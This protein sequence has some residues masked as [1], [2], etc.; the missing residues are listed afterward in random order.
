MSENQRELEQFMSTWD[1][2]AQKTLRL[3]ENLPPTQYEFRP[4]TAG[5]SLGELAWHLA[6]LEAYMTFGIEVGKFDTSPKPPGIER[7]REVAALAPGYQRVH[8]QAVARVRRLEP[9]DVARRIPF[10]GGQDVEVREILRGAVLHHHI[11]HRGQLALVCRL[12][13]GQVPS[14]YGPNREESAAMR[15]RMQAKS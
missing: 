6:E 7:P 12:A 15:A 1:Q 9:D 5:R 3:L 13:G 2:E 4:D 11:H 14:L 8:D 10:F